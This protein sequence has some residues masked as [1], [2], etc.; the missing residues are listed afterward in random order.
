MSANA[1]STH[2]MAFPAVV[3]AA[4]SVEVGLKTM[5]AR[6][7]RPAKGHA[8]RALYMKLPAAEVRDI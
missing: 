3:C 6:I 1:T 5:L 2:F 8:L 4:F 7:G